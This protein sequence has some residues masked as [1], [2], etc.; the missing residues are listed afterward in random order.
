[1]RRIEDHLQ[2]LAY[3]RCIPLSATIEITL[4]CNIRCVHCYNFD[5]AEPYAA[6]RARAELTRDEVLDAIDQLRALGCLG[7]CLTGGE[8]T[9]HPDLFDFVARARERRLDVSLI[10]NGVALEAQA[11]RLAEA[12]VS[13]L[14]VSL[15]GATA[16]VHDAV[17]AVTG[18]LARTLA[19]AEAAR[20]SGLDVTLKF[21][22][23]RSNVHE[24][25]S[26]MAL[27]DRLGLPPQFETEITGR[28]DGTRGPIG[29]RLTPEQL[30]R[31][32]RHPRL[33]DAILRETAPVPNKSSQC[34]CA[35]TRVAISAFGDVYPCIAAP[36]PAGNLRERPLAEIWK[37]SPVFRWIRGLRQEDFKTCTP[38]PHRATCRRTSGGMVVS[39]GDYTGIDPWTCGEAELL[40]RLHDEAGTAPGSDPREACAALGD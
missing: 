25:E 21:I 11:R 14:S 23:V 8:A 12:E 2:A 16:R 32:Y 17:T 18:S 1:M 13:A 31:V 22:L 28:Y 7:L 26:M 30:E 40:H 3:R 5:R 38:C 10:T 29:L 15:Y 34:N 35:R 36:L 6:A 39:A 4:R 24:L 33:R 37:S 27:A 19:G 9:V 20:A